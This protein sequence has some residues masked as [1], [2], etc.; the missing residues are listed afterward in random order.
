MPERGTG[1]VYLLPRGLRAFHG[2]G[3]GLLRDRRLAARPAP[4]VVQALARSHDTVR[5]VTCRV[6]PADPSHR[7]MAGATPGM[8]EPTVTHVDV[9]PSFNVALIYPT[10]L[11]AGRPPGCGAAR[12]CPTDSSRADSCRHWDT[13]RIQLRGDCAGRGAHLARLLV[14]AAGL[15]SRAEDAAAVGYGQLRLV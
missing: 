12:P 4:V 2:H 1:C 11:S 3:I 10:G 5:L 6:R 15:R 14:R 8:V 7:R 9:P 13:V